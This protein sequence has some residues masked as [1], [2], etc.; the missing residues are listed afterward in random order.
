MGVPAGFHPALN[1]EFEMATKK[2]AVQETNEVALFGGEGGALAP[3]YIDQSSNRGSEQ[4]RAEDMVLPRLEII[5]ALSPI[6]DTLGPASEGQLFNSVTGELVGEAAYF[7]PVFFRME[8]L[9]W[10]DQDSGGGFGG[11]YPTEMEAEAAIK[12]RFTDDPENE[13]DE[14]LWEVIDTPVHYGLLVDPTNLALCQQ[15]VISMARTKAKV[16]RKWNSMIQMFGGDRFSRVY[17]IGVVQDENKKGKKFFNFEVKSVGFPTE[18]HYRK[19]MELYE[20]F[21][22]GAMRAAHETVVEAAEN[23]DDP[24]QRAPQEGARRG[25]I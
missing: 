19:A 5:Q 13:E 7:I 3:S 21:K 6:K 9:C 24:V 10:Y 8:Y 12:K 20:I 17:R 22:A 25:G 23:G 16:S 14:T 1:R 11:S 15:I 2:P 18:P 4:V